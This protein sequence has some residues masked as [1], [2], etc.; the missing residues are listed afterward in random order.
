MAIFVFLGRLWYLSSHGLAHHL[1][2][3]AWIYWPTQIA[4]TLA[5]GVIFGEAVILGKDEGAS[6]VAVFGCLGMGVAWV[7]NLPP[8]HMRLFRSCLT[9]CAHKRHVLC[10][11]I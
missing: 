8:F 2:R 9:L 10:P 6:A 7:N 5:A 11:L 4:M 3:T 1:G